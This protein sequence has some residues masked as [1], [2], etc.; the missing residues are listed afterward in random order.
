MTKPLSYLIL[1]LTLTTPTGKAH[2]E[3]MTPAQASTVLAEYRSTLCKEKSSM[4]SPI[5]SWCKLARPTQ[6]LTVCITLEAFR[7]TLDAHVCELKTGQMKSSS[8]TETCMRNQSL[9]LN[10]ASNLAGSAYKEGG[11]ERLALNLCSSAHEISVPIEYRNINTALAL[12]E[13]LVPDPIPNFDYEGLMNCYHDTYKELVM[14][15][16]K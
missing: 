13:P 5:E 9:Q 12:L 14:R 15:E 11:I 2:S 16:M 10:K 6:N 7:T 3:A 8:E 1:F 4:C